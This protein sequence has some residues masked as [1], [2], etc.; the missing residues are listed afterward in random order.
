[1]RNSY[2]NYRNVIAILKSTQGLTLRGMNEQTVNQLNIR[3]NKNHSFTTAESAIL[4]YIAMQCPYIGGASVY[5][6]RA[7]YAVVNDTLDFMDHVLCEND[8]WNFRKDDQTVNSNKVPITIYPNPNSNSFSLNGLESGVDNTIQIFDSYGK[9]VKQIITKEN[10]III[11]TSD[12]PVGIYFVK[13]FNS[14]VHNLKL[15]VIR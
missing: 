13:V 7:L 6:A 3:L 9:V 11:N 5:T 12:M 2:Y 4:F 15:V 8:D 1:M 10:T 14:D